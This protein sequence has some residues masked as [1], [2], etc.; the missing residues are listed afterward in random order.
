M[1][2]WPAV[3]RWTPKYLVSKFGDE[4]VEIMGDREKD[5]DYEVNAE[6]HR[7]VM[8]FSDFIGA[9][10]GRRASNDL[11][12]VSLNENLKR[13]RLAGMKADVI[14]FPEY[15]NRKTSEQQMAVWIGP[16]GA[17]TPLHHDLVNVILA[18]V[19]GRKRVSLIPSWQLHRVYNNREVF[20]DLDFD[21]PSLERH[22]RFKKV[23]PLIVTL[24]AGQALFIPVGWWHH[25]RSLSF[26]ISVT[27]TH[28]RE[29]NKYPWKNA[30]IRPG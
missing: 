18:Q 27:F 11:Y 13:K 23:K 25:V 2:D 3:T 5:P 12:M 29:S 1:N 15:L 16:A 28:F 19:R 17:V 8:R 14:A 6:Q 30:F 22:P 21:D 20:S 24:R 4:P 26:S 9:I 10:S 7:R